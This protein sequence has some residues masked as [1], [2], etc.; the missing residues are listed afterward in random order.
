MDNKSPTKIDAHYG[1]IWMDNHPKCSTWE[2]DPRPQHPHER[3]EAKDGTQFRPVTKEER[4]AP[5]FQS[6]E[7]HLRF[8]RD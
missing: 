4:E 8:F 5:D 3:G 7:T 6:T 2:Y 1:W